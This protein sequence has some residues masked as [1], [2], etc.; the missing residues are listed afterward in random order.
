MN[1]L[2]TEK[3]KLPSVDGVNGAGVQGLA[4]SPSW[5]GLLATARER[6]LASTCIIVK[7]SGVAGKAAPAGDSNGVVLMP[8]AG[9]GN[10]RVACCLITEHLETFRT[11]AC[12]LDML[13]PSSLGNDLA[14]EATLL[15]VVLGVA[16]KDI[17][18]SS[19]FAPAAEL[20][21][22]VCW[23]DACRPGVQMR[24]GIRDPVK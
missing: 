5:E 13:E 4:L 10:W 15:A 12:G 9:E 24:W 17:C 11:E 22:G 23:R 8:A 14:L 6:K 19:A 3:P 21:G 7:C 18:L 16:S 20:G 1:V 2:C